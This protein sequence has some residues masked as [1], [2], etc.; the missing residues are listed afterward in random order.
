MK[1]VA[2]RDA[3]LHRGDGLHDAPLTAE[4]PRS[5]S[6]QSADLSWAAHEGN[7]E[8]DRWEIQLTEACITQNVDAHF[9]QSY[10]EG[11]GSLVPP[12][13]AVASETAKTYCNTTTQLYNNMGSVLIGQRSRKNG[14]PLEAL[15]HVNRMNRQDNE[16]HTRRAGTRKYGT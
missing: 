13:V 14:I 8:I 16:Q 4:E 12:R 3:V 10:R 2:E 5:L 6:L 1:V 15:S 9:L 11:A 7:L